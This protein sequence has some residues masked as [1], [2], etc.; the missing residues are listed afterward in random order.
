[1]NRRLRLAKLAATALLIFGGIKAHAARSLLTELTTR[2]PAAASA[3]AALTGDKLE[4]CLRAA[5]TLDTSGQALDVEISAI[6]QI[7]AESMFLQFVINS[8]FATLNGADKAAVAEFEQRTRRHDE[9]ARKF[10]ADYP[11]YQQHKSDYD[12]K[13]AAFERDCAGDFDRRDLEAVKTKL[14]IK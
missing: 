5:R 12:G 8:Q 10:K 2:P 3:K 7:T 4:A 6:E 14:Q 1:M 9:L 13:V 11:T